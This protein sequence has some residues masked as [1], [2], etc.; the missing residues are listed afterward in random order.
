MDKARI[1]TFVLLLL[2]SVNLLFIVMLTIDFAEE[3][4]QRAETR[5][6]LVLALDRM[7]I[8]I[9]P[10]AIPED[11]PQAIHFAERSYQLHAEAF[12]VTAALG[13]STGIHEGGGI[14][15]WEGPYGIGQTRQGS[16]WFEF[17][18][19]RYTER[20]TE[21]ALAQMG[22]TVRAD[23][24]AP[25]TYRQT[26]AGRQIINT[27]ITFRFADG[28]ISEMSGTALWGGRQPYAASN[29]QDVTTAL[30]TLAGH[31][32]DHDAV[33]RFQRVEMGY[34][35][36]EGPGYLELLPVWIIETDAGTF[37]VDRQSGEVRG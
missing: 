22:L 13:A 29:Q 35:L 9:D 23:I 7:G 18:R 24:N 19:Q 4:R 1:K 15:R 33:T 8:T 6:E 25:G 16:F 31:L 32:R 3:A 11:V 10:E 20:Q 5:A 17:T 27:H 28:Y 37:S 2:L 36:S 34:Y 12:L 14:Y 21:W 26:I 30:I